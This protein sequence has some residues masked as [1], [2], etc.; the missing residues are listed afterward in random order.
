MRKYVNNFMFDYCGIV[1]E[2]DCESVE[3]K[4]FSILFGWIFF[5]LFIFIDTVCREKYRYV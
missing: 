2:F 4:C 3:N 1:V 5:V